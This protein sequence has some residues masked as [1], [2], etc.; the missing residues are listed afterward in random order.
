MHASTEQLLNLRDGV[1]LPPDVAEHVRD[2]PECTA[3]L[4]STANVRDALRAL[5]PLTPPADRWAAI[6]ARLD[7]EARPRPWRR[8][9]AVAGVAASAVLAALLLLRMP[10]SGTGGKP[11][12]MVDA[13][14]VPVAVRAPAAAPSGL[15]AESQRLEALIDAYRRQQPLPSDPRLA[16]TVRTLE[17][18]VALVDYG[19]TYAAEADLDSEQFDRLWQQ[20]VDLMHSIAHVRGAEL[21]RVEYLD[22]LR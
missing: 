17:D 6:A 12:S 10:D 4:R 8:V 18:Q 1:S 22:G 16:G 15:L 2:C 11:V 9:L 3:G 21:R 7:E 13:E 20:R 14:S 5:P 19:L